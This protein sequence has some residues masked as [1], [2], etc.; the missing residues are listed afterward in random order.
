M[1]QLG[2]CFLKQLHMVLWGWNI[3]F[4]SHSDWHLEIL[5]TYWKLKISRF[6]KNISLFFFDLD[7]PVRKLF[8]KA[9][10]YTLVKL[11]YHIQLILMDIWKFYT[12]IGDIN[13][14][15]SD[16]SKTLPYSYLTPMHLEGNCFSIQLH[17]LLWRWKN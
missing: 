2:N 11:K 10:T 7:A 5:H 9:V 13:S 8:F 16:I 14:R 12:Y 6:F 15:F 17:M 3:L 4:S 1:I